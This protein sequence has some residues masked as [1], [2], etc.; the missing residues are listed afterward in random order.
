VTIAA[1]GAAPRAIVLD[2]E[3]TTS[4]I[5]FVHEV[6]F[7]FARRQLRPYLADQHNR[8][9]LRDPL[10]LLLEELSVEP[11]GSLADSLL[12][13]ARPG[14]QGDSSDLEW[15][16][17]YAERLMDQDRKSPGLKRLQGLIWKG[18]YQSGELRGQVFPDV[19]PAMR[20]WHDAQ[21]TIAIYSSG[22]ELAQRLLFGTTQ[23]GD[24]TPFISRFFDTA[25]GP[26]HAAASYQRIADDLG[27]APAQVLFVSDVT[28][29]L[30][31]ARAAG[32]QVLLAIRPGNPPPPPHQ[33]QAITT[34]ADVAPAPATAATDE[35]GSASRQLC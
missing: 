9:A 26:K 14:E 15:A 2:I 16:A 33:Y 6:L 32:C 1:A 19:A 3:G 25:V 22:S 18:G 7:P 24:L 17:A 30:D 11:S 5:A 23:D 28:G 4:P 27:C 8:E 10:R 21:I 13:G 20:R 29:E 34:L 31:A 35:V 12:V